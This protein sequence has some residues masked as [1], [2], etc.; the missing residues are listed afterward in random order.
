MKPFGTRESW[1]TLARSSP[2]CKR[3]EALRNDTSDDK[4]VRE[5][6]MRSLKQLISQMT[7]EIVRYEA[8]QP[9]RA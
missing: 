4:H 5:L 9:T 3:Y 8:H 2:D 1:Q 7:E 6:S